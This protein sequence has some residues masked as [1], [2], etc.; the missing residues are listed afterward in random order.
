MAY[1]Q[2]YNGQLNANSVYN[3]LFN[4]IISQEVFADNIKGTNSRLVEE[5]KTEGSKYGDTIL[6]ISSDCLATREW[7]LP[8]DEASKLLELHLPESPQVQA[9]TMDRF[10]QIILSTE[11]YRTAQ[12]WMDANAFSQFNSVM[13]GWIRES[14]RVY[15][16]T[17]YNTTIGTYETNEGKQ[18]VNIS[19]PTVAGDKESENRQQAQTIATKLADI[20]VDLEDV[21]RDYNDYENLRSYNKNDFK[22]VFS[23]AWYNKILKTD[24]SSFY[25]GNNGLIDKLGDYVLPS[26]YFGKKGV[27]DSSKKQT[28]D[29]LKYRSLEEQD[30]TLAETLVYKGNTLNKG[31]K[32]H[33][34]A[35][36][37]IPKGIDVAT[38]SAIVYPFYVEDETIVMKIMHKSDFPLMSGF[39]NSS[40]FINPRSITST[41]YL[42]WNYNTLQH[43]HDKPF[44][45]IRAKAD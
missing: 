32:L 19:L 39:E 2:N 1:P 6:K 45:T 21:S 4:M 44:I 35:G 16:S 14:K 27:V 3:L 7:G 43:I 10:R 17:L 8:Q 22:Y 33:L 29:G 28:S 18:E 5:A 20:I 41:Q 37:I 31:D 36:D 11:K 34:F 13:L 9:I 30:V 12:A 42:T 15:D 40:E 24:L 26:K 38:T 23:S 25:F